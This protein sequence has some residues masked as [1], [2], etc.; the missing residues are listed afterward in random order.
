[1]I[2]PKPMEVDRA[3]TDWAWW[4]DEAKETTDNHE[5][6]IE[7]DENQINYVG[8]GKGKGQSKGEC[9]TCGEVGHRAAECRAAK[10]K[11]VNG[12]GS[13]GGWTSAMVKACF[14]CGSTTNLI[15]AL[16]HFEVDKREKSQSQ[17]GTR[18]GHGPQ[19]KKAE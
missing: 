5:Q 1:M 9:W 2:T 10:A 13:K 3:Q 11:A 8:K 17:R 12:K 16:E 15:Q 7:T 18:S 19:D 6:E 4:N 14:G